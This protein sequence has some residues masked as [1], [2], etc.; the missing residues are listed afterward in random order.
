MTIIRAKFGPIVHNWEKLV[1]ASKPN[2]EDTRNRI[3]A[4]EDLQLY[5]WTVS[6]GHQSLTL[7]SGL[8]TPTFCRAPSHSRLSGR[9]FLQEQRFYPTLS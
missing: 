5:Y 9:Y 4:R 3:Q 8:G 7:T 1:S 6:N 2:Q